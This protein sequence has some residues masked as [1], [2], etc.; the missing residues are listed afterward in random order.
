MNIVLDEAVE[1]KNGGEKVGLG[2]VVRN[3]AF[4]P[5]RPERG[6]LTNVEIIGYPGQLRG[7]A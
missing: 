6:I 2:M 5:T 4:S 7:Y 3:C 1:E